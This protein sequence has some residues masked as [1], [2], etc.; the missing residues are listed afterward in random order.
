MASSI[1][2]GKVCKAFEGVPLLLDFTLSVVTAD[3]FLGFTL[4]GIPPPPSI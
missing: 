3:P 1:L 4:E 2:Y